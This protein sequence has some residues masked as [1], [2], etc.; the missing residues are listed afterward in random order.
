MNGTPTLSETTFELESPFASE[1]FE[2]GGGGELEGEYEDLVPSMGVLSGRPAIAPGG[3]E[4]LTFEVEGSKQ[5]KLRGDNGAPGGVMRGLRYSMAVT[6]PR[7]VATGQAS[8]KRRYQPLSIVHPIGPSSPQLFNAVVSNEVLKTVKLTLSRATP[9]GRSATSF[10]ITL[11]NATVA[12]LRH[13]TLDS[14]SPSYAAAPVVVEEVTFSFA[15]IEMTAPGA[16]T[17]GTDS[18]NSPV[19]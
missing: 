13:L 11:M 14:T 7:D 15:K 2:L 10:T 19:V 6:S 12:S 1:A 18:W 5:G 17:V 16:G 4:T 9:D 8:G 3:A